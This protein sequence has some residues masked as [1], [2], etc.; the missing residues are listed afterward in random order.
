MG[1]ASEAV[2]R[3]Q[4]DAVAALSRVA[5]RI[6]AAYERGLVLHAGT[7]PKLEDR[8]CALTPDFDRRSGPSSDRADALVRAISGLL[9]LDQPKSGMLN[10]GRFEAAGLMTLADDA[11]AL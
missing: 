1:G 5:S 6:A 4:R 11:R 2:E 7:V 9:G 10:T 8:I 3:A